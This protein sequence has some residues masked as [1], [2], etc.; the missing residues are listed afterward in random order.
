MKR[1]SFNAK[2]IATLGALTALSL[3]AFMIES[4]F[5]PLPLPGAKLGLSNIFS[6]LALMMYSPIEGFMVAAVRTLLGGIFSGNVSTLMYSFTAGMISTGAAALMIYLGKSRLSLLA[7]S[8]ASAVIHNMV[9]LAVYF[10]AT[11]VTATLSYAPYLAL[12][13][14]G[15]GA[16]VG[17]ASTII[18][19]LI[20]PSFMDRLL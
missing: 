16:A 15:A 18:I 5:P 3:I 10:W 8:I 7:V 12:I 20:P 4:L 11:G 14:I 1:K 13:G 19:K 2:K 6:L 17:A 9:Q